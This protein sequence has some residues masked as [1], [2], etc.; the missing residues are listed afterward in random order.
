[1]IKRPKNFRLDETIRQAFEREYADSMLHETNVVESLLIWFL[2]TSPE[3]RRELS[4]AKQVWLAKKSRR[5]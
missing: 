3:Q 2:A 1:M 4:K 5:K